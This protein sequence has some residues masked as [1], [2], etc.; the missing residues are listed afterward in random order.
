MPIVARRKADGAIYADFQ[1]N[2]QPGTLIANAVRAGFAAAD[3]LEE[4]NLSDKDYADA[5]TAAY[6]S[7]RE[8][9]RTA[10]TALRAQ[11]VSVAGSAVGVR[12][13]QLTAAQVRG[14][15]AL[16]LFESGALNSDGTVRPLAQ[17]VSE[18]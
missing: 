5:E 4:V 12:I 14:L 1:K 2:A 10:R 11:V 7:T 18:G 17:W 3:A 16:L 6:A 8:A 9:E 15:V 13:D